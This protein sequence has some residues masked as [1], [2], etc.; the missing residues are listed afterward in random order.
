MFTLGS[1]VKTVEP[2]LVDKVKSKSISPKW[3]PYLNSEP[4][5]KYGAALPYAFSETIGFI[6]SLK[7][8]G[9]DR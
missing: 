9:E 2:Q 1:A 8:S 6:D 4:P 3:I 5:R 7:L